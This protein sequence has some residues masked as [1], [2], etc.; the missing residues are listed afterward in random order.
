VDSWWGKNVSN[1]LHKLFF[2]HFQQTCFV[3]EENDLLLGF[4]IGF[5]SQT[6]KNEAYIHYICVHPEYRQMKIAR[7]L[8]EAFINCVQQEGCNT[9]RCITSPMNKSSI[10]FH[11]KMGFS[12]EGGDAEIDGI[13]ISSDY[14]GKG[15]D[16]VLFYKAL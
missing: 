3:Y 1:Q 7:T 8:Y 10:A 13:Q 5:I 11:T 16:R 4:L 6:N 9:I 12:I 2:I 15:Q 14:G